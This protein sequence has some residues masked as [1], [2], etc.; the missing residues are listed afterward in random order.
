[1]PPSQQKK[2]SAHKPVESFLPHL[3]AIGE[4]GT[5]NK[6]TMRINESYGNMIMGCG[7]ATIESY[8][9]AGGCLRFKTC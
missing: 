2:P 8:G 7:V 1:M 5:T 3:L 9:S 6:R 4:K